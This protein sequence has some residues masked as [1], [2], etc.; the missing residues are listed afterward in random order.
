M[1]LF[2][3]F[4]LKL[5]TWFL[6][7]KKKNQMTTRLEEG[8]QTGEENNAQILSSFVHKYSSSPSFQSKT[9]ELALWEK[10]LGDK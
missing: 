4:C 10:Y 7:I 9:K 3:F 6:E 5:N 8:T 1:I 2:C